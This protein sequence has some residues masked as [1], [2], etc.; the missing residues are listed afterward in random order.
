MLVI[1][2]GLWILVA[3]VSTVQ[4]GLF[5]KWL[6]NKWL[7]GR[8]A[9]IAA[10]SLALG[11]LAGSGLLNSHFDTESVSNEVAFGA[12]LIFLWW[13]LFKLKRV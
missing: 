1:D 5:L 11:A 4:I 13:V 2:T 3:A 7:A 12:G 8:E 6:I 10:F 9:S